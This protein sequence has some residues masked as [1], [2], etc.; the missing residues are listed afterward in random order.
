LDA[1]TS[2]QVVSS[3][4]VRTTSYGPLFATIAGIY[5]ASAVT[6][7]A[8]DCRQRLDVEVR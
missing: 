2:Q 8:I 1:S 7:L 3:E 6:W 4:V 5:L